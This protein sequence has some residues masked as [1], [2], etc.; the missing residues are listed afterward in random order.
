MQQEYT[1]KQ[2]AEALGL[3]TRNVRNICDHG[4][5]PGVRRNSHGYRVLNEN[6]IGWL[7][8]MS[9][10]LTNG[11]R[12]HELRRLTMLYRQGSKTSPERKAFL[13]TKK[14]QAWQQIEDLQSVISLI[15]TY[16]ELFD[17]EI[18]ANTD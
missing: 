7:K 2:A 3:K 5:V 17:Q 15:E 1:L 6:Q 13:Q 11:C 14:R 9:G 4:L 12:V 8:L 10:L 18:T 16:E